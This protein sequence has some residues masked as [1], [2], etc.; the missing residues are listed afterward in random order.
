MLTEDAGPGVPTPAATHPGLAATRGRVLVVEDDEGLMEAYSDL[1]LDEG[2]DVTP[3]PDG[4]AAVRSLG[5]QSFDV[6]LTDVV[7]PGWNGVDV[8]RVVR[9]RDLDVPVVL[10]T[11]SPSVETAVQALEMGALHY[12]LKPVSGAELVRCVEHAAQLRKLV[13][14]K[15]EALRYL[16]R[17]D[18][19]VGDRAGLETVFGR[20][21]DS[22]FMAYQPIVR[23]RDGSVFAWEGLLRTREPQVAGPLAFLEMAERLGRVQELG[24]TIRATVARTAARTRGVMFFINLHPDDLLD[25]DLYDPAAPLSALAS[26]VVLE[27]TERS[28]LEGVPDMRSRVARLRALGFRLAVDDLGSGYAGLA[29]FATL[30]PDFVKIDRGLIDGIDQEEIKRRLVGSIVSVSRDMGIAVVAEGVETPAERQVAAE[31]GCD[32]L[33]GFLFRRP[34]ELHDAESFLLAAAS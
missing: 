9:E 1:L 11:G 24:R 17:N 6:V 26:E 12:L 15:R 30:A 28:P 31:L 20:A 27:I 7:M 10:V 25:E 8:L 34:E 14:V 29:S 5:E 19:L 21:L 22:L 2:F 23:T 4:E 3:A 16:G 32:L 33:Q 13:A 18:A